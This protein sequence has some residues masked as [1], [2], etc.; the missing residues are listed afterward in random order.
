M[1]D[2]PPVVPMRLSDYRKSKQY[3][4][5]RYRP[6]FHFSPE[7]NWMND[8][9]GLVY[10]D[11][12]YH[13]FYQHNP[14]GNE[15]GHMSWGHAVST[16][17][18]HWKHLPIALHD[19]YGVMAFS[20]CCVV[21][22]N[23]TS[24]FG[25]NGQPPLVAVYTGHG[26][27]NQTQDLA[28]SNDRGRTWTKFSGNPVLDLRNPNFRDPKVFWSKQSQQWVMLVSLAEE[29]KLQFYGSPDL[30]KWKW[31]SDF[32]NAGVKNK[33]NWECPDLFELPVENEKGKTKW[34]LEVDM[35]DGSVAGGSGGE[36]FVG[37]F[38]GDSLYCR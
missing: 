28:Y 32:E 17:L 19:E 12:E 7:M 16:D 1:T 3:Y 18:V 34:V 27:G 26:Y 23:N 10:Y 20:G 38:D 11:G 6:Q 15:W 8:P 30:K 36:Y 29:K 31:L 22:W 35:G 9:N 2:E 4:R 21:D 14:H 37:E 13:L 24:G 33:P 25:K 5:E